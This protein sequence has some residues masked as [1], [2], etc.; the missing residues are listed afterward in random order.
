MFGNTNEIAEQ[1][2]RLASH[3][4]PGVFALTA[5]GELMIYGNLLPPSLREALHKGDV[6]A[7]LEKIKVMADDWIVELEEQIEAEMEAECLAELE[8][9]AA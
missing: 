9:D 1:A 4:A 8:E 5:D 6:V 7:I 3:H 2:L